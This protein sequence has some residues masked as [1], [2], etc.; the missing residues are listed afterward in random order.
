MHIADHTNIRMTEN[1]CSP[2]LVDGN[3]VACLTYTCNMFCRST[4]S[5]GEIEMGGN[6]A[7]G[8]TNLHLFG[9]PALIGHIARGSDTSFEQ[10]CQFIYLSILFRLAHTYAHP[11]NNLCRLQLFNTYIS[12]IMAY[13]LCVY[14]VGNILCW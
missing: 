7:P 1:R 4:N 2:I 3:H 9:E 5:Q 12:I 11:Q 14:L 6:R 13:D 8:Q 10:L